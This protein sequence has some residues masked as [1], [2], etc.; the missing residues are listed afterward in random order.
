MAG[1]EAL[2][3]KEVLCNPEGLLGQAWVATDNSNGLNRGNVY[4]LA[5]VGR[6]SEADLQD[7]MFARSE[8]GGLTWS[9]PVRINDDYIGQGWQWMGTM[10][11]APDGRIDVIW[12]DTRQ[13]PLGLKSAL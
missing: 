2:K 13:N 11:V 3:A 12:L 5:S 10:S 4:L 9:E 7:V 6:D 8:D 1:W